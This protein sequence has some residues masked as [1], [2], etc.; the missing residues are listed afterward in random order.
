MTENAAAA[1][2]P[3]PKAESAQARPHDPHQ[4]VAAATEAFARLSSIARLFRP[5]MPKLR[6][7][8]S[9]IFVSVLMLGVRTGELVR[10]FDEGG[11]VAV[12]ATT[13]AQDGQPDPSPQIPAPEAAPQTPVDVAMT[14]P[15]AEVEAEAP[16][17]TAPFELGDEL[18]RSE[19][20]LLRDLSER[21]QS[22]EER[23]QTL[24]EREALLTVAEQRLEEKMA[25]LEAVR[26][27]IQQMLGTLDEQQESQ[28]QS[29]V[30][31]YENMR[32][33]DAAVIFNGLDIDVLINVLDR[34]REQKSAAIMA[35]M[36]PDRARQVTA[37][38]AQRQTLP[39]LGE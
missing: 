13:R 9:V 39:V 16:A 10:V 25:E 23:A 24:D 5:R 35:G 7:L 20:E 38:L 32:P 36:N 1:N 17:E 28:F 27:Q 3:V 29:L 19:R 6:L 33:A 4:M 21:R 2:P 22:L 18:S 34:M 37:E 15:E 8:P 31:I 30:G 14:S 12:G 11:F 26:G